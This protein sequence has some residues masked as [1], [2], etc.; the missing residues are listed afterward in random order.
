MLIVE[1]LKKKNHILILVLIFFSI[2]SPIIE[3]YIFF[4]FFTE[5]IFLLLVLTA[6]FSVKSIYLERSYL[7]FFSIFSFY[8]F[9]MLLRDFNYISLK[10]TASIFYS[11]TFFL[12]G[13]FIYQYKK[14]FFKLLKQIN[15]YASLIILLIIF[16]KEFSGQYF[17]SDNSAMYIFSIIISLSIIHSFC[18]KEINFIDYY[19][20]LF[21]IYLGHLKIIFFLFLLT[22]VI[23]LLKIR[24]KFFLVIT[25]AIFISFVGGKIVHETKLINVNSYLNYFYIKT[26]QL[27]FGDR[28]NIGIIDLKSYILGDKEKLIKK[29]DHPDLGKQGSVN[30]RLYLWQESLTDFKKSKNKFFGESYSHTF[31]YRHNFLLDILIELGLVGLTIV[32]F[33]LIIFLRSFYKKIITLDKVTF[34]VAVGLMVVFMILNHLLSLPYYNFK[35]LSLC[36]GI[37]FSPKLKLKL[38]LKK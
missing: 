6:F 1:N 38:K 23:F 22:L 9:L 15:F 16:S 10:K 27:Y 4:S 14:I 25:L 18:K 36:L 20:V 33:V 21:L 32:C 2:Y 28:Y 30:Y 34:E 8:L 19:N 3:S 29:Y 31:K 17:N 11:L 35:Y 12:L 24:L 7:I 37:Y 26:N 13:S 5:S